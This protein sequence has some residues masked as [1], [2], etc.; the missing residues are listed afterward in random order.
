MTPS[1]ADIQ[2]AAAGSALRTIRL[3]AALR[4]ADLGLKP[5]EGSMS[6]AEQVAHI[7]QSAN[8]TR[9]LL[10]DASVGMEAFKVDCDVSNVGAC[11]DSLRHHGR[12]VVE[13]ASRATPEFLAEV[14]QPFG[15]DW[16]EW[17]LP[18]GRLAFGMIDHE[19]HHRGQL[20]VYVRMAGREVPL[21]YA[22]VDDSMWGGHAPKV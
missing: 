15:P 21:L 10:E 1:P 9:A 2:A 14:V 20:T 22:P 7:C 17:I 8:F 5:G 19:S 18:R 4:D 16:K 6:A 13:A 11:L 12:G 3:V